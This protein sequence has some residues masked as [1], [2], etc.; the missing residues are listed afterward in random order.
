VWLVTLG[1][2]VSSL[3]NDSSTTEEKIGIQ[4]KHMAP[5]LARARLGHC[6]LVENS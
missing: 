6:H 1:S 4:G 2:Q 5:A 3:G